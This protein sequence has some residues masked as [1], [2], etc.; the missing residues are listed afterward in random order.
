MVVVVVVIVLENKI[1][2]LLNHGKVGRRRGFQRVLVRWWGV[3]RW[4][5]G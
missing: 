2:V 3:Y 5:L 4:N 1:D